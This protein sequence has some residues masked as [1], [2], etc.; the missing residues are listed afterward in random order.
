MSKAI[1]STEYSAVRDGGAGV[2][3]LSSRGR[4]LVSGSEAVM[5]LNGLITNDMKTLA[6]NSWMAAIF[7][8][9]QGRLL[10]AVR[11]I[12]RE[13]GFLIDTE[14]PTL[15]TVAKLLERFTLAGDFRVNNLTSETAMLSIQGPNAAAVIR[16]AFGDTAATLARERVVT[17]QLDNGSD[18]TVI[19]ATHTGEDGFDL[20]VKVNEAAKLSAMISDAGAQPF[21]SEVAETLRIEAGIPRFGIDM[22]ETRVVTETNLDDA[23]SFTKGCYIGQEIIARIKYRGHVAK[24]L[25]GVLVEHDGALESGLNIF[26][27]DDKEIGSITSSAVSPRLKQTI[28]LAYLKYD[29]LEPGTK[30]K[31]VSAEGELPATVTELPFIRGSWY[32]N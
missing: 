12:H 13:D 6:V 22:D 8:N 21:G 26:S 23:V 19:R 16:Q 4:L 27:A 24:K 3:D 14:S 10:A 1:L 31:V 20:F 15:E 29:Y 2:I 18:V 30:V 32:S 5:F 17:A 11:I 28:A 9:V 7:P 25:T